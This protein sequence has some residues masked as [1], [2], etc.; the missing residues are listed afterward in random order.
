MQKKSIFWISIFRCLL[1][2]NMPLL[3]K[4]NKKK[5]KEGEWF[6]I[7]PTTE[8]PTDPPFQFPFRDADGDH[9]DN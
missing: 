7:P 6:T 2:S 3:E 9:F 8:G 5:P 1:N 4:R